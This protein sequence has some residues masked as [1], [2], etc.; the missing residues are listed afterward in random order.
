M[1]GVNR[2]I[3]FSYMIPVPDLHSDCTADE[4]AK[5][6]IMIRV[7][8]TDL[9]SF[10]IEERL[11]G[12]RKYP[13]YIDIITKRECFEYIYDYIIG[14]LPVS[15][16][17]S[18]LAGT[19]EELYWVTNKSLCLFHIIQSPIHSILDYKKIRYPNG[20]SRFHYV[21]AKRLA[22]SV[23]R[24]AEDFMRETER[25]LIEH[26]YCM[27]DTSD[28]RFWVLWPFVHEM[29]LAFMMGVHRKLGVRSALCGF[30]E[31]SVLRCILGFVWK[32]VFMH[33]LA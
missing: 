12:W 4:I 16:N 10:R 11:E 31:E 22:Y 25:E 13:H 28:T 32:D 27:N 6:G 33:T 14:H 20:N 26:N 19:K 9:V 3:A 5:L 15:E 30:P 17:P 24:S 7:A 1:V 29:R 21:H 18:E 23:C 2:G 8:I